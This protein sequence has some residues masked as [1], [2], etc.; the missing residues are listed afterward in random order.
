[1]HCHALSQWYALLKHCLLQLETED[2][3]WYGGQQHAMQNIQGQRHSPG[4]MAS[5]T[6]FNTISLS[7]QLF[8]MCRYLWPSKAL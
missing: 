2:L 4:M 1:M 5:N 3:S 6:Q 8:F 7:G